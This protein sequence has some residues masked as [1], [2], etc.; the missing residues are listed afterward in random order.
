MANI[1]KNAP[2][3]I[4]KVNAFLADYKFKLPDGYIEFMKEANGAEIDGLTE[5]LQ[6]WPL[7]DLFSY[8]SNYEIEEFA[9]KFF[10]FGSNGGET[11][12]LFER[13]TGHIFEM[14][15]MEMSNDTA[16]FKCSTFNELM[17]FVLGTK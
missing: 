6:I 16:S 9:P 8:N 2:T 13:E 12:Y 17:S 1:I 4:E 15:F 14:P 7:T 3:S 11:A 10:L 5:Y